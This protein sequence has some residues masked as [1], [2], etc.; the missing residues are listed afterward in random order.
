MA[1]RFNPGYALSVY[2]HNAAGG[3]DKVQEIDFGSH[4][5]SFFEK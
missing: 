1:T 2:L 5:T 3:V 4:P